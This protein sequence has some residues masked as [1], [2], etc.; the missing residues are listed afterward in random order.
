MDR[1]WTIMD[2]NLRGINSQTRWDDIRKNVDESNCN[3]MCFQETKRETFDLAYIKK[4][5]PKRFNQFSY[6]PSIGSSRSEERRV[7]KEC[8][9]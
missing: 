7:G 3:V 2:W 9:L 5:C 8:R 4:F 6:S 1:N